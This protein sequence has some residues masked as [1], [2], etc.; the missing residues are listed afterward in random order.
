MESIRALI[1]SLS[2]GHCPEKENPADIPSRGTTF[3]ELSKSHLWLSSPDW[4]LASR[5]FPDEEVGDDTEV[6]EECHPEMKTKKVA[7]TMVATQD[8]GARIGRLVSCENFSSL[9]RL[10]RVTALVLKF[11]RLLIQKVKRPEHRDTMY[12]QSDSERARLLWLKDAQ[13]ELERDSKFPLWKNQLN[14]FIDESQLWRCGG[15]IA[16]SDLPSL[17]RTPILID[18]RHPL[19]ALIVMSAY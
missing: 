1:P 16:N 12:S 11:T 9:S 10:L 19:A 6:P 13:S 17:A 4:L 18:N 15:R 5:S 7:H 8:H 2:W 14:L 3:S